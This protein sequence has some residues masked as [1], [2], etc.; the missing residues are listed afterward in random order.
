MKKQKHLNLLP[1]IRKK[2]T[3]DNLNALKRYMESVKEILEEQY[4][5]NQSQLVNMLK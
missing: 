2:N 3:K 4:D 5:M 1:L